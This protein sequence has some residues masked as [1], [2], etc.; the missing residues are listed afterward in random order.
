MKF[1]D[2]NTKQIQILL[3]DNYNKTKES[4]SKFLNYELGQSN[5]LSFTDSISYSLENS[6]KNEENKN[7]LSECEHSI[8]YMEKF[9][10]DF[11]NSNKNLPHF[12]KVK[13]IDSF[14]DITDN[15][16]NS[17]DEFKIGENI[18]RIINLQINLKK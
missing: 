2:S 10:N 13:R 16:L 4:S 9:A 8:E 6:N 15:H 7:K 1:I 12:L 14:F 17:L 11:L 18:H 3:I 5:G